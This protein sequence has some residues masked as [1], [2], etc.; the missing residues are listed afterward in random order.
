M[1]AANCF[2]QCCAREVFSE[3]RA[4]DACVLESGADYEHFTNNIR[5]CRKIALDSWPGILLFLEP[6]VEGIVWR[7]SDPSA[8]GDGN[9]D[10]AFVSN[11]FEHLIQH[12]L[13][14]T[15]RQLWDKL[16]ECG[17]LNILHPGYRSLPGSISTTTRTLP[18]TR[19]AVWWIFWRLTDFGFWNASR[20]FCL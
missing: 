9:V 18:L 20:D 1:S 11:L 17:T 3:T 4:L 12:Q 15:L 6:G 8:I 10:F 14:A 5:C 19:T 13:A 2:G 7:F 16:R